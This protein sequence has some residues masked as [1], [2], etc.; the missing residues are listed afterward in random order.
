M[1]ITA[2]VIVAITF[3]QVDRTPNAQTGTQSDNQSLKNFDRRV[4][5]FHSRFSFIIQNL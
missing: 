4:K 2:G 1:S 5:E 3:Q